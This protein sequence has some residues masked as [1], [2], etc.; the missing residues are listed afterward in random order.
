MVLGKEKEAATIETVKLKHFPL[1]TLY[2]P[3][4]RG[5]TLTLALFTLDSVCKPSEGRLSSTQVRQ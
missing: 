4:F 3:V 1:R 2:L 5:L